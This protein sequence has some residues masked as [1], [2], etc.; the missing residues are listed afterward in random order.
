MPSS[1]LRPISALILPGRIVSVDTARWICTVFCDAAK[2]EYREVVIPSLYATETGEGIHFMPEVG[3]V[4]YVVVPSDNSNPFLM[5]TA[6]QVLPATEDGQPGS[7][8]FGRPYLNPGDLS[9][10]T[11]DGNGLICRRGGL[12]ELRGTSLS[13]MI[14]DPLA[15]QVLTVAQNWK[16]HTIGGSIEWNHLDTGEG[17]TADL[18]SVLT[19]DAREFVNSKSWSTKT[20]QGFTGERLWFDVEP[21]PAPL[22]DTPA[23]LNVQTDDG[24]IEP[25]L[26]TVKKPASLDSAAVVFNFQVNS[27]E[28]LL[29]PEPSANV[30][31]SRAG[32]IKL[33]TQGRVRVAKIPS[34]EPAERVLLGETFLTGLGSALSEILAAL[35]ALGTSP[36]NTANIVALIN[37]INTSLSNKGRPLLSSVIESE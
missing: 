15:N 4:F 25:F 6:P 27:D 10:F 29:E 26:F 2:R 33:Q 31:I 5:L 11:R 22:I 13:R 3:A 14:M 24:E 21:P 23:V 32:D 16:V 34:E 1:S 7:F 36:D 37:S 30:S 35:T 19:V 18:T 20:T 12:T 8:H 28:T 9:F 17:E